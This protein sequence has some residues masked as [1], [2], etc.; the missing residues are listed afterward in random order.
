MLHLATGT[1]DS[2]RCSCH[3]KN[4]RWKTVAAAPAVVLDNKPSLTSLNV[5]QLLFFDSSLDRELHFQRHFGGFQEESE[6][7]PCDR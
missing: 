5:R 2:H 1:G 3:A 7:E 4:C 6:E